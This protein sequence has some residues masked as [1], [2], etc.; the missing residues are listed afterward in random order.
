MPI[1]SVYLAGPMT[2]Y[3]DYNRPAFH[4]AAATLRDYGYHVISPAETPKPC[5]NPGWQDWARASL[6]RMLDANEV[7]LMPG[8]EQSR[9]AALEKFVADSLG[10]PSTTLAGF[11]KERL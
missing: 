1:R 9:G 10:M 4:E 3:E 2:G 6:K 7:I 11:I 8:W 5:P